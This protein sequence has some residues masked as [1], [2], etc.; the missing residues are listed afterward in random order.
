MYIYILYMLLYI[1]YIYIFM[2]TYIF[3]IYNLIPFLM[4][5]SDCS[6]PF[7]REIPAARHKF[8]PRIWP[9]FDVSGTCED[10]RD[11][12]AKICGKSAGTIFYPK[13]N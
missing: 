1:Y 12:R 13:K 11:F 6:A 9:F 8:P 5:P 4:L 2:Y 7:A 3:I 10:L